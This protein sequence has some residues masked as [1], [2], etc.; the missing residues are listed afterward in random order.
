M[1]CMN[2]QYF[3]D[4]SLKY[5]VQIPS[6]HAALRENILKVHN[7]LLRTK[8]KGFHINL[9]HLTIF[10]T[11]QHELSEQQKLFNKRSIHQTFRNNSEE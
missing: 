4:K 5:Y 6:K 2:Q 3:E 11:E 7:L 9:Y 8:P 1:A 10:N